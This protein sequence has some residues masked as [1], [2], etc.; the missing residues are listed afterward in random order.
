MTAV[1][2]A[3][4]PGQVAPASEGVMANRWSVAASLGGESLTAKVDGA[5]AVG[6]G[7]LELAARFR[8]RPS[9]EFALDFNGGGNQGISTAGVYLEFRYRFLAERPWNPYALFDLGIAS[10]ADKNGT[11]TEKKGRGSLRIGGGIERRIG[12]FGIEATLR[13][14]GIAT[15]PEMIVVRTAGQ[16]LAVYGDSGA[17]LLIGGSYYF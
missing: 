15:N 7:T 10:A 14:T 2:S 3:Q 5:K 6:F 11:D 13:L 17:Q 12:H 1:A 4:A 16:Q 8:L 9:I